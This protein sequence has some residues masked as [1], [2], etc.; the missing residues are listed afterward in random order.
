MKNEDLVDRLLEELHEC[1][2]K[3]Y[4]EEICLMDCTTR[5]RLLYLALKGAGMNPELLRYIP[6]DGEK[7]IKVDKDID[8]KFISHIVVL[9]DGWILD[10]VYPEKKKREDFEKELKE[11]NPDIEIESKEYKQGQNIRNSDRGSL[12]CIIKLC[13]IPPSFS[14]GLEQIEKE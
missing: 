1:Y 10:S 4:K 9:L 13:N 8:R 6:K 7:E 12:E 3:Y 5:S 2:K 11:M 14:D